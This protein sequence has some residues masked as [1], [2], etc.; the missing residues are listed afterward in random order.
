[1]VSI[2]QFRWL[3]RESVREVRTGPRYPARSAQEWLD[4]TIQPPARKLR[5]MFRSFLA[6]E[7]IIV[8]WSEVE[9]TTERRF[10]YVGA[11]AK[12][13]K[14]VLQLY[15]FL[16]HHVTGALFHPQPRTPLQGLGQ[17]TTP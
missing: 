9:N 15:H 6:L 5:D 17:Q 4:T 13:R 1:M 14:P 3:M 10:K 2:G 16:P 7:E 11:K 8:V 12:P